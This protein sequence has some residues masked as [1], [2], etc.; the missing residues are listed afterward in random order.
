[1]NREKLER[2]RRADTLVRQSSYLDVIES[3]PEW[4]GGSFVEEAEYLRGV[5]EQAWRS[6]Y[7]GEATGT[8]GSVFNNIVSA[9]VRRGVPGLLAHAA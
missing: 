6:E 8:G 7:L 4:L 2:E 1:M 3:H 9:P 5:D